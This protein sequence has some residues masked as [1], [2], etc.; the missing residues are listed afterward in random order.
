M[1]WVCCIRGREADGASPFAAELEPRSCPLSAGAGA[2]AWP[3]PC[4]PLP[5]GRGPRS[6]CCL[7]FLSSSGCEPAEAGF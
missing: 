7:G 4:P 1:Q 2:S 6:R 5:E 3:V